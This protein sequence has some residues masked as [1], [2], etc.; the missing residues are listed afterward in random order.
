MK[1]IREYLRKWLVGDLLEQAS[2]LDGIVA[3]QV[4]IEKHLGSVSS[5]ADY[6]KEKESKADELYSTLAQVESGKALSV[7]EIDEAL[8]SAAGAKMAILES[9]AIG[10][11]EV[12]E[13]NNRLGEIEVHIKAL[14]KQRRDYVN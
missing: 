1:T 9:P 4:E 13:K 8:Q 12:I 10:T 2:R 6:V 14:Q 5:L 7:D 11:R 3:L